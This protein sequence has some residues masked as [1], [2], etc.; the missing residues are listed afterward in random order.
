M[1]IPPTD[2]DNSLGFLLRYGGFRFLDLGDLTWNY[3]YKL[4]HPSDKVGKVDVY[5]VTHHGLD[6]SNNTVL[7]RTV[8]PRVAVCNNGPRKGGSPRVIGELRRLPEIQA[9]YQLHR[10]LTVSDAENTDPTL[11]ANDGPGKSGEPVRIAV[12]AD[13]RSYTVAVGWAGAPRRFPTRGE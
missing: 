10:N 2:N 4:V 7:M 3:E 5:Q 6:I 9:V 1:E 12:A 13:G 11:I 8:S